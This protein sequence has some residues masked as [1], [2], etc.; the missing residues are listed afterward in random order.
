MIYDRRRKHTKVKEEPVKRLGHWY[1]DTSTDR[2]KGIAIYLEA[3]GLRSIPKAR[4][5]RKFKVGC[6]QHAYKK[7]ALASN[8][9]DD[10]VAAT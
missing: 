10:E 3:E 4:L 7:I 2:H 9:D 1:K 5:R 8:D 6:L